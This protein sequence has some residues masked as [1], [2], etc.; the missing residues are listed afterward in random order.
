MSRGVAEEA[1]VKDRTALECRARAC[2]GL[3]I[4]G[5]RYKRSLLAVWRIPLRDV[6]A[7]SVGDAGEISLGGVD[8]SGM[9][10]RQG[11]LRGVQCAEIWDENCCIRELMYF[12]NGETM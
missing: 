8:F 1:R 6:Q 2:G 5:N 3:L 9:L 11:L 7:F 10:Q 12:V 4:N